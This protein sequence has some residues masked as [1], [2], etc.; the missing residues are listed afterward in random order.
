MYPSYSIIQQFLRQARLTISHGQLLGLSSTTSSAA[1]TCLGGQNTIVCHSSSLSRN[2][3]LIMYLTD[4]L[5]AAMDC[6]VAVS[7][8][9]I[10]FTLQFPANGTIG[11]NSIQKWW[12]NT[13]FLN[14]AD[15]QALPLLPVPTSGRFGQV[16]LWLLF[17]GS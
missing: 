9:L 1:V 12:G 11:I 13:V 15:A 6:G 14:T 4:I 10:Y 16:P 17:C 2:Y 5:S 7:T 8:I 3:V